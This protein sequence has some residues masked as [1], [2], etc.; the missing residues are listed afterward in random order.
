MIYNF[1][2][3]FLIMTIVF[4]SYGALAYSKPPKWAISP[5]DYYDKDEYLIGVG[6]GD[7][8]N[9]A[10]S[11]AFAALSSIFGTT[12]EQDTHS[13]ETLTDESSSSSIEQDIKLASEHNLVNVKID[14]TY[15]DKREKTYYAIAIMHKKKTV[16]IL[17]SMISQNL[18]DISSYVNQANDEPDLLRKYALINYAISISIE[19]EVYLSQIVHLDI[20]KANSIST[21]SA[22]TAQALRSEAALVA[23]KTTFS[24]SMSPEAAKIA[25]PIKKV[26]GNMNM[27]ISSNNPVYQFEDSFDTKGSE[28]YGM[29]TMDYTLIITIKNNQTGEDVKTFTFE[30]KDLGDDESDATKNAMNSL[31][32]TIANDLES[33]FNEYLNEI[34]N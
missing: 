24:I 19:N 26:L 1:K 8:L 20:I 23:N 27:R 10:K 17:E 13:K 2:N 5:E 25:G 7:T 28:I 3:I 12:I 32:K 9:N 31:S 21:P 6:E 15:N 11:Q 14:K 33:E 30:G 18:K 29:Y 22:L 34:L 4:F 16:V